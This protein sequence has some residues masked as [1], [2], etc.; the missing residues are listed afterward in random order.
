MTGAPP[1]TFRT[2]LEEM[3]QDLVAMTHELNKS[4]YWDAAMRMQQVLIGIDHVVDS[5]VD[6]DDA[7][8]WRWPPEV[9][10]IDTTPVEQILGEG[11]P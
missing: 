8:D 3:Q 6:L 5:D 2:R 11:E 9:L 1:A 10:P 4:H 7:D